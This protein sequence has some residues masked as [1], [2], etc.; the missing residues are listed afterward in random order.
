M[1]PDTGAGPGRLRLLGAAAAAVGATALLAP[2][3]VGRMVGAPTSGYA[4]WAL[5]LLGIRDL[6]LAVVLWNAASRS[7]HRLAVL[8]ARL[9]TLS[10]VADLIVTADLAWRG[11]L[12]TRFAALVACAAFATVAISGWPRRR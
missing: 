5:R 11:K 4:A 6:C 7:D 9:V 8:M 10:Q 12:R 1:P 3:S 2:N